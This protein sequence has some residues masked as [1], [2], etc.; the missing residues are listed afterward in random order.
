MERWEERTR[1][2]V[3]VYG[4][5]QQWVHHV[6]ADYLEAMRAQ[7]AYEA[8]LIGRGFML[9]HF[10]QGDAFVSGLTPEAL[11]SSTAGVTTIH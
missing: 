5:G 6:C 7:F 11:V 1:F 3:I 2:I 9:D 4:P 10:D 8:E